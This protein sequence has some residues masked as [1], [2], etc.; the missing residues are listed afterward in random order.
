MN[1]WRHALQQIR[2]HARETG[3]GGD[4]PDFIEEI[5]PRAMARGH[6]EHHIAAL[7]EGLNRGPS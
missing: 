4:V 7:V 1:V 5:F 3:I 6:G 2:D